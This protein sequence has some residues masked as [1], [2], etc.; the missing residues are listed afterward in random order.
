MRQIHL[1]YRYAPS[2]LLTLTGRYRIYEY[3]VKGL[4]DFEVWEPHSVF[5]WRV[6]EW[7]EED[8]LLVKE[9]FTCGEE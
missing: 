8:D 2:K 4:I 9:V 1:S 3:C 5:P 6:R 7:Y